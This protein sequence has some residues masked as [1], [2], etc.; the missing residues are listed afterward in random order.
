MK[1]TKILEIERKRTNR[2][3]PSK[4]KTTDQSIERCSSEWETNRNRKK[5]ERFIFAFYSSSEKPNSID[6]WCGMR[7]DW[8]IFS[9][10]FLSN[11]KRH[12]MIQFSF[13]YQLRKHVKKNCGEKRN[14]KKF[15]LSSRALVVCCCCSMIVN[16]RN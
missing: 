11:I 12:W 5:V 10:F 13:D 2:F 14:S 4:A 8:H 3:D 6:Y 16:G 9:F 1:S 15:C 7:V